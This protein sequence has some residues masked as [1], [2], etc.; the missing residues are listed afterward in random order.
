[1]TGNY[2][3]YNMAAALILISVAVGWTTYYW[4]KQMKAQRELDSAR[5][6]VA[7]FKADV[8]KEHTEAEAKNNHDIISGV[9][10]EVQALQEG[11]DSLLQLLTTTDMSPGQQEYNLAC[12]M[13]KQK[14]LLLA[15]L[16]TVSLE[17]M[18]YESRKKLD[19]N[20]RIAVN[21]FCH[22]VFESCL[23]GLKEGIETEMETSLD[24]DYT[25]RTDTDTLRRIL[26]NLLMNSVSNTRKG[27]IKLTIGE[28]KKKRLLHFS[29]RDTAP[30]IPP[31][32]RDKV[33]KW[34]PKDNMHQ[35]LMTLRVRACRLMVRLLGGTI[36]IDSGYDKGVSV[37][38]TVAMPQKNA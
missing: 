33:F 32:L 9:L 2:L 24:D 20:E 13:I 26:R 7:L 36:Y 3:Y 21:D 34:L 37:E 18:T 12:T 31:E 38:F 30:A 15:Q 17:L 22:D 35:M 29:V 10:A 4:R 1:M 11:I 28:N 23:D 25:L 6:R 27:S 8:S 14:S 19:A 5:L 16:L